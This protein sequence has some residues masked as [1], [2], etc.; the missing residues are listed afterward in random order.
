MDTGTLNIPIYNLQCTIDGRNLQGGLSAEP[1]H[2]EC[3]QKLEYIN[4]NNLYLDKIKC[5]YINAEFQ[6]PVSS[7]FSVHKTAD[8]E[9][10]ISGKQMSTNYTVSIH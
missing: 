7:T 6:N 5:N 9:A 8:I 1:A 2:A 3:F 4:I 10:I